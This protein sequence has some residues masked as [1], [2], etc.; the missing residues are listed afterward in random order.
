MI[1]RKIE[2]K[3]NHEIEQIIKNSLTE[4]GLPTVG[5]TLEDEALTMMYETYQS[6]RE[7]YFVMEIDGKVCGGGGIKPLEG[8]HENICELQKMYFIPSIR[9]K[10]Y[11]KSFFHRCIQA[12]KDFGYE[13]CYLESAS[14][15]KAAIHIYENNGFQHLN[16]PIGNTGHYSC[17]VWMLKDLQE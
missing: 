1:I 10:G 8:S 6:D 15:L 9:G 17:E 7:V 13:K 2:A 3:D 4:F 5:T 16:G 11:G 12:A 14:N